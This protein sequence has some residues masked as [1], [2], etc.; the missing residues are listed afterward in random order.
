MHCIMDTGRK[1]P[2]VEGDHGILLNSVC[3]I[4]CQALGFVQTLRLRFLLFWFHMDG[5]VAL[6]QEM[7][8]SYIKL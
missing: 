7:T 8:L 5:V 2:A 4:A 3:S 1:T 6:P